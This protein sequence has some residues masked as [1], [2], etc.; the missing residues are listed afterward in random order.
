MDTGFDSTRADRFADRMRGA[1]NGAAL[2]LMT[3][4]GH[5]TGLFDVMRDLAPSDSAHIA[6]HA[7]LAERYVREWLG[8]MTSAGVLEH[9]PAAGTFHL[10][11]EHA[12]V[13]TRSARP[14]NLAVNFQWIPLL[15][16]VEDE[17]VKCFE[18]DGRVP[19]SAYRRCH[20]VM[21][22]ESD[23]TVVA[24]LLE[25]IVPLVPG[26]LLELTG[27][28]DVLDVG[29]GTGSALARLAAAFPNSRFV[30]VDLSARAIENARR[31]ARS[32][33]L[34]NLR[35]E[36]RDAAAPG[37]PARFDLITAFDAIHRQA[38]PAAVL[39]AIAASL[40]PDGVF[41]MQDI[42]AAGPLDEEA[43]HPL[44][45]FLYTVACLHRT[46][47]CTM[48]GPQ[49]A[50]RLLAEAGFARVE[51]RALPHDPFN[52]YYVARKGPAL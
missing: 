20:A 28:I 4:V 46:S 36:A 52:L 44:A 33:G 35:F 3:S 42:A 7:G 32:R 10:P 38:S 13:L 12:S 17:I 24:G 39:A 9:D 5:R 16:A 18:R 11:R 25:H 41:L 6:R 34:R 37:E 29:C 2:G 49:A 19:P 30:G 15:G 8:A 22:E 50:R 51:P 47:V 45:T 1:L 40:R 14:N 27:G 48:W 23:Q 31:E 21:A 26:L 43:D